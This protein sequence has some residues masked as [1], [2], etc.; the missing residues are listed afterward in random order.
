MSQ[1]KIGISISPGFSTGTALLINQAK[2]LV[3]RRKIKRK[4]IIQEINRF[5]KAV[6][7]S[8]EEVSA[9]RLEKDSSYKIE[10]IEI[11]DFNILILEDEILA[12]EVIDTI[13][14]KLI[15]AE[16]ALNK[17]LTNKSKEFATV[18]DLYM[19]ERLA[20]FY[21]I[22]ERITK[23]L[24]GNN[25][26][27]AEIKN[28]TIIVAHDLS[29]IDALKYCRTGKIK[30][31][32]TDLGGTTSHTAIIARS[33]GI[34]TIMSLINISTSIEPGQKIYVD[35]YKGIVKWKVNKTEMTEL[36]DLRSKYSLLQENL[37]EFS[38]LSGETKDNKIISIKAN[39][40]IPSEVKMAHKYGAE[41]IGMYRTEFLFTRKEQFP[42][43]DE[44]THDYKE[45]FQNNLFN[46]V[47][48]RTLDIGGDK[49]HDYYH[50]ENNPA[51]GLR[52]IR[53]SLANKEVFETQ[54]RAI[55]NVVEEENKKIRILIPMI[56]TI[57]EV[58][59][60]I[61]IINT[62]KQSIVKNHDNVLIGVV[63]ETPSAAFL[64]KEISEKIDFISIGTNDLIQYT[65]AADRTNENLDSITSP[66]QPSVL[67]MLDFI[68]KNV[69]KDKYVSVCGEMANDINCLP[70]FVGLGVNELSMNYYSIPK[71]KSVL[72]G[73]E[74]NECKNAFNKSLEQTS[75]FKAKEV[76]SELITNNK[77]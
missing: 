30:G 75:P 13:R 17:V 40:E 45:L 66:F 55:L 46:E 73:L 35:G 38:K 26:N 5:Q 64:V 63:I 57:T 18:K 32:L 47:T 60:S 25:D 67:R 22:A 12:G 71:I 23:N 24:R 3:E 65:L 31:I 59:T 28:N 4:E 39:I 10:R 15:N 7:I 50:Q 42:T 1:E 77:F 72:R 14:R 69:P 51:L 19:Q 9:I 8:K 34:P 36:E 21:Y 41:G 48:I 29:P 33:M 6:E 76:L 61:E 68:I 37:F 58:D 2:T 52:G 70:I 20:D 44:Q 56:S 62:L 49:I 27:I 74:F 54:L 16:W 53:Y 43:L 11:L